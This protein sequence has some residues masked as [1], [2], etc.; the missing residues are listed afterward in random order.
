MMKNNREDYAS[1]HEWLEALKASDSWQDQLK[2]LQSADCSVE[3]LRQRALKRVSPD[4]IYDY[5]LI[6]REKVE[7][8]V[9]ALWEEAEMTMIKLT[10]CTIGMLTLEWLKEHG[11]GED[12]GES[13]TLPKALREGKVVDML[14][15]LKRKGLLDDRY[16]P[17]KDMVQVNQLAAIAD[18][19]STLCEIKNKW[20]P[21]DKLWGKKPGTLRSSFNQYNPNS[22]KKFE[23]KILRHIH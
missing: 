1:Y 9:E 19:I 20:S 4:Y 16:Q 23:E 3:D 11:L 10:V 21:F 5:W 13:I 7:P 14:E 18:K 15:W 6:K 22:N 2:E 8:V 12:K 17:V